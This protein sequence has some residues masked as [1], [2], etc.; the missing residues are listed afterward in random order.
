MPGTFW[1]RRLRAASCLAIAVASCAVASA[2]AATGMVAPSNP[3]ADCDA[4]GAHPEFTLAGLNGCR[5]KEGVGP[6]VLPSNWSAL[7]APE[8][9]LVLVDLERVNRG[10]APVIGLS[11]ALDQLAAHGAQIGDDPAFPSGGFEGGGGIWFGGN[12]TIGADYAWMYDDGPRGFDINEDCPAGGGSDCWLHRDIIL[13]NGS[14]GALV[15]GGGSTNG[16]YAF[17]VLAG[18]STAGLTFTWSH[19]LHYFAK[20]PGVDPLDSLAHKAS[21]GKHH[22][23][24]GKSGSGGGSSGGNDGLT[25]TVG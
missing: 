7:T 6:M 5:A 24:G 15:G 19:E 11:P 9:M 23:R 12:S 3:A 4:Q 2:N 18:Y 21:G 13:W 1:I 10:L 17:E 20:Q 16:S 14:G 25:I 22:K 8:Q